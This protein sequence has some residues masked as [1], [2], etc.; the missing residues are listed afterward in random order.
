[1]NVFT[2]W[3]LSFDQLRSQVSRD[4]VKSKLLTLF[5]YFDNKDI[6]EQMFAEY[7]ADDSEIG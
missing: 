7:K 3:E 2:T 6:S 5:A 4:N 1:M